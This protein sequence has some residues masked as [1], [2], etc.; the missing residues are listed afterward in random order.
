MLSC[1]K[2]ALTTKNFKLNNTKIKWYQNACHVKQ[3][4]GYA[5]LDVTESVLEST[6]ISLTF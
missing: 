2:K 4:N 3:H 5:L 1:F 6:K